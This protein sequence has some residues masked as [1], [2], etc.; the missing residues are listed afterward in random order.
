MHHIF[1]LFIAIVTIYYSDFELEGRAQEHQ[2][3]PL[4]KSSKYQI[5]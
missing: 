3:A 5:K 1:L 4:L 2:I